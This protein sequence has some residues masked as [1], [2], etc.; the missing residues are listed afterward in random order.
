MVEKI[1]NWTVDVEKDWGGRSET[2]E[3]LR[4]GMPILLKTF[5]TFNIRALLFIST[6][7]LHTH[8]RIIKELNDEGHEIA[9]HGHFHII[10]EEEFRKEADKKLSLE[11]LAAHQSIPKESIRYRA[12]KFNYEVPGEF[13]S[14]RKSHVSLLKHMWL[15]E[16]INN[17]TIIYLH[18]FD[19]VGGS[20]PPNL[21]CRLWYS[22]P[23]VAYETLRRLLHENMFN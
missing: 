23:N 8:R 16:R 12:P 14:Y 15:G 2:E 5:R 9:S 21:F 4:R 6:E 1:Y 20:N 18:P 11:L 7:L 13:Y 10:Y 3:G 22:R 19:I 17:E